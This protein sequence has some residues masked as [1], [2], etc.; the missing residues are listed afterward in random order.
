MLCPVPRISALA[1][2]I[3]IFANVLWALAFLVPYAL[4]TVDPI[5]IAMGRYGTYG[6]LS[7]VLLLTASRRVLRSLR[8]Q[9]WWFAL[10][11]ALAGNV[12]YYTALVFAIRH[13]GVAV[14]VLVIGTLPITMALYGNWRNR[15]VRLQAL[16]LPLSL[17]AG[18]LVAFNTLQFLA[19]D[20]AAA[21]RDLMIGILYALLALALWTWFG[22]ANAEYMKR[23]KD[24][25]G[26]AWSTVIGVASLLLTITV[27]PFLALV[28]VWSP[29]EALSTMVSTALLPYLFGSFVLGVVVSWAATVLWNSAS[30]NLP[31]SL[32]GQLIV[33]ETIFSVLYESMVDRALPEPLEILCMAVILGGVLLGIRATGER[34][35]PGTIPQSAV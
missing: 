25:S 19:A 15:E 4:P 28:G 30:R 9:D 16:L 32:A 12:G 8:K 31:V 29:G 20:S 5:L 3:G 7:L 34:V 24:V 10:L 17:I 26:Q 14:S 35:I 23:R 11:F 33:F 27:F 13:A 2:A 21:H 18:G 6:V 1:V 22:V